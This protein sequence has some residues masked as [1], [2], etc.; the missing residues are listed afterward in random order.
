MPGYPAIPAKILHADEEYVKVFFFGDYTAAYV[1]LGDVWLF[2]KEPPTNA[3]KWSCNDPD[4]RRKLTLQRMIAIK[5]I[6]IIVLPIF[7]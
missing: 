3:N 5:V 6:Y 4:R 1:K 7:I 2:S